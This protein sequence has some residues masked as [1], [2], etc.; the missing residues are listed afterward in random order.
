[1]VGSTYGL[2]NSQSIET[3]YAYGPFGQTTSSGTANGNP[4]KFAGRELDPNSGLYFMRNRYYSPSLSRFISPDPMGVAVGDANLYL[5][6]DNNPTNLVDPLG[7][8]AGVGGGGGG[9]SG[10]G[11]VK[12]YLNQ[13]GGSGYEGSLPCNTCGV[14]AYEPGGGSGL[15]NIG[16]F[17]LLGNRLSV[18]GSVTI[19][20]V[21]ASSTGQTSVVIPPDT[22]GLSVDLTL[23]GPYSYQRL[24]ASPFVGISKNLSVGTNIVE[25]KNNPGHYSFQGLNLSLGATTASVVP[26]GVA[27]PGTSIEDLLTGP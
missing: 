12:D 4:Y 7:L 16:D 13:N 24:V 11:T 18:N 10:Y 6:A 8:C 2:V 19:F 14:I 9:G 26:F 22:L 17:R 3:Q 20:G 5:Y 27:L 21:N 15:A 23:N 1:V 25:D